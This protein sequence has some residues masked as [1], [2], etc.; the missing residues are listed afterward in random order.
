MLYKSWNETILWY[1]IFGTMLVLPHPAWLTCSSPVLSRARQISS[2]TLVQT[3]CPSS[4]C[5][6]S[7]LLIKVV[8]MAWLE[9]PFLKLLSLHLILVLFAVWSLALSERF[10]HFS[11]SDIILYVQTLGWQFYSTR[12]YLHTRRQA[13]MANHNPQF[14]EAEKLL[15][16]AEILKKCSSTDP[17]V[18]LLRAL[19]ELRVEPPWSNIA[20]PP[21]I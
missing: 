21:G 4:L 8:M 2:C 12:P 7:Q 3:L 5:T 18:I 11:F 20:L 9:T 15:L 6:S 1:G 14:S 13:R 10:F 19:D 17:S 16:L